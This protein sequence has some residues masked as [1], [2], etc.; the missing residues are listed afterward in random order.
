MELVA[1]PAFQVKNG[2]TPKPELLSIASSPPSS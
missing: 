2:M 1:M